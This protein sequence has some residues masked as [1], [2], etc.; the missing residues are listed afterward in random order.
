[1]YRPDEDVDND[2]AVDAYYWG[3]R[4]T[5]FERNCQTGKFASSDTKYALPCSLDADCVPCAGW[6]QV[7]NGVCGADNVCTYMDLTSP[8]TNGVTEIVDPFGNDSDGNDSELGCSVATFIVKFSDSSTQGVQN[9]LICTIDNADSNSAGAAPKYRSNGLVACDVTHIGVPAFTDGKILDIAESSETVINN[10]LE[11]CIQVDGDSLTTSMIESSA[12][13]GGDYAESMDMAAINAQVAL[14]DGD[15]MSVE[16]EE[17]PSSPFFEI[18]GTESAVYTSDEIDNKLTLTFDT[19]MPCSN[20]GSCDYA[21]GI[22][23]CSDGY[24]GSACDVA[25]S[26]V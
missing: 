15:V 18:P 8:V 12:C 6:T 2:D 22:C 9:D 4:L 11:F 21:T 14:D 26:Y 19:V 13:T 7:T 1:M 10:E 3:H 24:T 25:V 17:Y 23:T 16:G 20:K 5:S